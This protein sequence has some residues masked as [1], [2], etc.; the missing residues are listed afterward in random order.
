MSDPSHSEKLI[1]DIELCTNCSRHQW[2]THHN[3][4]KYESIFQESKKK[5]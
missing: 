2:C 3:Q 4:Q 1:V 5:Y